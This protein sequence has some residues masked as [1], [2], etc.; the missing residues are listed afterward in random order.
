MKTAVVTKFRVYEIV[1]ILRQ[2]DMSHTMLLRVTPYAQR[3]THLC[4]AVRLA[5][6]YVG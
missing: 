2:S 6:H 3:S 5:H 1:G 4:S